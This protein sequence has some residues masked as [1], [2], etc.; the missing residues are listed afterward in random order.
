[1]SFHAETNKIVANP[2]KMAIKLKR[3]DTKTEKVVKLAKVRRC[4][5][6][7]EIERVSVR[8]ATV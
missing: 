6:R 4:R 1:M 2:E 8:P 3:I 7:K 5:A